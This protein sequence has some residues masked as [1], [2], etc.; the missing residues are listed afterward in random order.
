MRNTTENMP[1]NATIITTMLGL[2][3]TDLAWFSLDIGGG[4]LDDELVVMS[5]TKTPPPLTLLLLSSSA[6]EGGADRRIRKRATSVK[7]LK[8]KKKHSMFVAGFKSRYSSKYFD[9]LNA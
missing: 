8:T 5:L 2:K 4:E 7:G 3:G 6:M 1:P 9:F